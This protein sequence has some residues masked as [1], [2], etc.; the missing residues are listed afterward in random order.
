MFFRK[1]KERKRKELRQKQYEDLN[2][3]FRQKHDIICRWYLNA[4]RD[5][6]RKKDEF[7][8]NRLKPFFGENG[9]YGELPK[10]FNLFAGM[11]YGN[12]DKFDYYPIE[13]LQSLYDEIEGEFPE[14]FIDIKREEKLKQL[15]II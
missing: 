3:K 8:N 11:N 5:N 15:G 4:Y 1:R 13:K 14:A 9:R 10:S 6:P 12:D 2:S 7:I